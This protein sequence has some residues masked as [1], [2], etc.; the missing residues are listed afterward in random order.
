MAEDNVKKDNNEVKTDD[1]DAKN[2]ATTEKKEDESKKTTIF[3][4]ET[5]GVV[6]LL[7]ATL[8]LIC[9]ITGDAIFSVPGAFVRSFLLG[10]FGIFAYLVVLY[11]IIS[12]VQL[13]VDK[14]FGFPTKIKVLLTLCF[15]LLSFIVQ[16][17]AMSGKQLTY[18]QYIGQTYLQGAGGGL[19][20]SLIAYPISKL[21][22]NAGTYVIFGI[23]FL[24]SIYFL[25]K[26]IVDTKKKEQEESE[27]KF[28]SSF[29]K[30]EPK[31][32]NLQIA[33]EMEY[34][35]QDANLAKPSGKQ[36]LFVVNANDFALK[37]KRDA[38]KPELNAQI[39]LGF[40]NGGLGVASSNN[41]QPTQTLDDY[42]SKL[43]Y[44]KKPPVFN[45]SV[46]SNTYPTPNEYIKPNESINSTPAQSYA[47]NQNSVNDGVSVSDY[48]NPRVQQPVP[49]D[50]PY[51][52]H[53]VE[54]ST[55]TENST[56]SVEEVASQ[57]ENA[58]IE[59]VSNEQTASMRAENFS[60]RYAGIEEVDLVPETGE[61]GSE[62]FRV[63]IGQ[64][65]Q[66]TPPIEE[67]LV[68]DI[69]FIEDEISLNGQDV[70]SQVEEEPELPP[71]N[72]LN[73][74]RRRGIFDDQVEQ[75][76]PTEISHTQPKEENKPETSSTNN[77]FGFTTENGS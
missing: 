32:D 72:I 57:T 30:E 47:H 49:S 76:K 51:I 41:N 7:F 60:R 66:Q 12:G 46:I 54:T 22:T 59:R 9:L 23:G 2:G 45:S 14:N 50:I 56:L 5:F 1:K 38:Q 71:T 8:C 68:D 15:A 70:I 25:V 26:E 65:E 37:N 19:I 52:E 6:L 74:S 36:R 61:D 44:I 3:T 27:V 20:V 17:I 75:S 33:G 31:T 62:T 16:V 42:K 35:V 13:I 18:G 48:I 63:D 10:C 28:N 77:T 34:P 55:Q 53:L 43:E 29:V 11:G 73:T 64:T 58:P 4:K 69:P 24:V 21:L 39:K 40:V 67:N